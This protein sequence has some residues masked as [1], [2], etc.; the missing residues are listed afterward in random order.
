MKWQ[1][2]MNFP[3]EFEGSIKKTLA[4]QTIYPGP[5]SYAKKNNNMTENTVNIMALFVS[6]YKT[7]Y[8]KCVYLLQLQ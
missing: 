7:T 6:P 8:E 3:R 2:C 4:L 5:T 1:F